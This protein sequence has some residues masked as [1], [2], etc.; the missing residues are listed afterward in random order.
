MAT[1]GYQA[2]TEA[3]Q[4]QIS[5]GA[6]AA[7]GVAPAAQFQAIRTM[8]ESLSSTKTRTR[9]T[10]LNTTG[11]VSAAVTTQVSAG[12]QIQFGLSYGTFDDLIAGALN[13]TWQVPLVIAGAAGDIST[14]AAGNKLTSATAG[15]FTG[16]RVGSWIRTFGFTNAANNGVFRVASM[17]DAQT[18]VLAGGV[19]VNETPAG[20]AA[21]IRASSITNGTTFNSFYLQKK[22]GAGLFLAYPGSYVSA[23]QLSGGIGKFLQGSFTF[24]SQQEISATA[25]ASTGGIKAAPTGRVHDPVGGFKGAY[26]N[27][28]IVSSAVDSFEIDV[29]ATGAA[30]E[31]GMG[32]AAAAGVIQGLI[33][34]KGSLKVYFKDFTL[35]TLFKNETYGALELI[36][37][38][39]AANAYVITVPNSTLTD[40]KILAGGQNQAV[41]AQ[42]SI[43]GNPQAAGGSII[44]DRLAAV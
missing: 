11:E 24:L 1:T 18:L 17:P 31:F 29:T 25:D 44:I 36:T 41:M 32:S 6:E 13:S 26:W 23:M 10:E 37:Y 2:G 33:E 4:L 7:W 28:T 39:A 30:Q 43:E 27:E 42:F 22:F 19:L 40:P 20:T 9:P 15:K 34:V 21:Q 5:Y 14:V 3:N 12:G 38:D 8:S 35:Y 16:I